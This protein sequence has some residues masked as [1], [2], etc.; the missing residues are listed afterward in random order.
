[1]LLLVMSKGLSSRTKRAPPT[2]TSDLPQ[3]MGSG[4]TEVVEKGKRKKN[5]VVNDGGWGD[6]DSK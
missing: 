4:W 3:R 2:P 1:M 5:G 6:K